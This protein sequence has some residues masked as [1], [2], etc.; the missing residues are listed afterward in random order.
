MVL[1]HQLQHQQF[2]HLVLCIFGRGPSTGDWYGG[3][4]D[5]IGF[6]TRAL[7]TQELSQLY[8]GGSGL[9]YPL[10]VQSSNFFQLILI[11][12]DDKIN[13]LREELMQE[14]KDIKKDVGEIIWPHSGGLNKISFD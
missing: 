2:Q 7:S 13:N 10:T 14:I 4:K 8:N 6:W 3:K 11:M 9:A 1:L 12:K 5:E